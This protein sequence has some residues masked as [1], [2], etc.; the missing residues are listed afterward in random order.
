[1]KPEEEANILIE[2]R[3]FT[4]EQLKALQETLKKIEARLQELKK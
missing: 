4:E 1:L 2:Q 3:T